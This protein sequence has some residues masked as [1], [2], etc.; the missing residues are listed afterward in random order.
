MAASHPDFDFS[1]YNGRD[2][3][4]FPP[5][6]LTRF[7]FDAMQVLRPYRTRWAMERPHPDVRFTVFHEIYSEIHAVGVMSMLMRQDILRPEWW[8]AQPEIGK[9]LPK[10]VIL[11]NHITAR[12]FLAA[13]LVQSI[14]RHLDQAFRQLLRD[15]DPEARENKGQGARRIWKQLLRLTGQRER[16]SV[17]LMLVILRDS[18]GT[19]G[20]FCPSNQKD[21]VLK[22]KG[23]HYTFGNEQLVEGHLFGFLDSWDML[24]FLVKELAAMLQA[25]FE[26]PH[27]AAIPLI[28]T[29]YV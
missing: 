1:T 26:S 21:L 15:L 22:Y 12:D 11:A 29:R 9:K 19:G 10:E 2:P 27:V 14:L 5:Q 23:K 6:R 8:E 24:L 4:L 25:I 18:S 16:E 13:G 7:A 20:K 28:K 17:L 3:W